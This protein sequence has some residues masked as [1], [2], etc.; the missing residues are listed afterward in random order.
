MPVTEIKIIYGQVNAVLK[1]LPGKVH[2]YCSTTHIFN[3]NASI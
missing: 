2:K 3:L 1:Y